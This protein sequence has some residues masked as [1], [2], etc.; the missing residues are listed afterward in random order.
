M[1]VRNG[2]ACDHA[3]IVWVDCGRG[4]YNVHEVK[5]NR[6][7]SLRGRRLSLGMVQITY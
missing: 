4:V 7:I 6:T 5:D 3:A 2:L 1:S